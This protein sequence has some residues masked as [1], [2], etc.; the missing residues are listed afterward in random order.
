[1][2]HLNERTIREGCSTTATGIGQEGVALLTVMLMLLIMTVLG[3]AS[4]TVTGLEN[5]MSGFVRTSEAAAAAAESCMGVSANIV[6]QALMPQNAAA[7]PAPFLSDAVPPG[8]V[9]LAN[10]TMLHD[11]IYGKDALGASMANNAD[12]AAASPNVV[13]LVNGFAVNGDI[14]RLYEQILPGSGTTKQIMYRIN[15]VAVNV[16]TGTASP[17]TVVYGCTF[18]PTGCY[19]KF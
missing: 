6:Q 8:P 19:K 10:A 1:M 2:S 15:C 16:A 17:L 4:I 5:R 18:Y 7:I 3:I 11:E 12:A 9:P 13:I 14:D